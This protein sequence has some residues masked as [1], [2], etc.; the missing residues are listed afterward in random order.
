LSSARGRQPHDPF[1]LLERLYYFVTGGSL[2]SR[3][4]AISTTSTGVPHLRHRVGLPICRRP[5][6]VRTASNFVLA[7]PVISCRPIRRL[8]ASRVFF[9]APRIGRP[10][11]G[12]RPAARARSPF[13]VATGN[14]A[15]CRDHH[16]FSALN[17]ATRPFP[18]LGHR[19][20]RLVLGGGSVYLRAW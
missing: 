15:A 3:G 18:D 9:V 4:V 2:T 16:N 13:Y 19:V 10:A 8:I 5:L 11:L 6:T 14:I 1:T 7:S 20:L 12:C 17:V